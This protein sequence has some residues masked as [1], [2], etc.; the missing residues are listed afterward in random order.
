MRVS[1]LL[2]LLLL[3]VPLQGTLL[4]YIVEKEVDQADTF[5]EITAKIQ[6]DGPSLKQSIHTS[7]Q[8]IED[9]RKIVTEDCQISDKK[10]KAKKCKDTI[11]ESKYEV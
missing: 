2:G 8:L 6:V 9:I 1:I 5:V 3:F 4:T 11:E 7:E 10:G